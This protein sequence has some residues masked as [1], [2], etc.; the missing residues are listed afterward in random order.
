M[1]ANGTEPGSTP[2][3]GGQ[4]RPA[5]HWWAAM[6]GGLGSGRSGAVGRTQPRGPG[7]PQVG[8]GGSK[9]PPSLIPMTL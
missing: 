4:S 1:Y 6:V 7:Q 2:H 3:R 8:R 9:R 5:E